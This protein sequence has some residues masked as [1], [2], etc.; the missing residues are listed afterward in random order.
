[1]KLWKQAFPPCPCA[2]LFSPVR[3]SLLPFDAQLAKF[4]ICCLAALAP[5]V[6]ISWHDEQLC[7]LS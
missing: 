6:L 3:G 7:V 4:Q 5:L 2:L 1:M